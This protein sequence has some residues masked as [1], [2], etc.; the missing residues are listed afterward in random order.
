MCRVSDEGFNQRLNTKPSNN[1]HNKH[2]YKLIV[3]L[4]LYSF[5][6]RAPQPTGKCFLTSLFIY[7]FV[8]E[9][10]TLRNTNDFLRWKKIKKNGTKKITDS[11]VPIFSTECL[12]LQ[13]HYTFFLL[14]TSARFMPLYCLRSQEISL[15]GCRFR[16]Q[17][18]NSNNVFPSRK[19]WG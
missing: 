4:I 11:R 18:S 8:Y 19:I 15:D 17:L 3:F 1:I 14:K 13:D 6:Y 5:Q 2:L 9:D 12:L 7:C 16:R 10:Q